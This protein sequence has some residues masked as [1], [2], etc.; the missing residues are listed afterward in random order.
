MT[1][2][3]ERSVGVVRASRHKER[4]HTGILMRPFFVS[5]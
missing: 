1:E 3:T 4:P 5:L 2:A